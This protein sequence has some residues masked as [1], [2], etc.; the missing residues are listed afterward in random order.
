[1]DNQTS[2]AQPLLRMDSVSKNY[3]VARGFFGNPLK[4]VSAVAN[5]SVD[6]NHGETLAIVGESGSGKSTMGRMIVRLID[7]SSG[8]ISFEGKAT[9]T[10]DAEILAFRK[11]VQIVFQDPRSSLNPRRKLYDILLDPLLLHGQATRDNGKQAVSNLLERVGLAPGLRYLDR[12][13]GQFSGGQLQRVAIARAIS[14]R[15]KLI[16][17]DEP[18][19]A[20]DASVR[21]QILQLIRDEQIKTGISFVFITHDLAVARNIA[22]RVAVMYLGKMVEVGPVEKVLAQ[23]AHPYTRA[24]L[25][26]TP[27]PDPRRERARVRVLLSG[28]IPSPANPPP[29]CRFHTRCPSVM[30]ICKVEEPQSLTLSPGHVAACHLHTQAA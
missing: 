24:L 5:V 22:H 7:P 12:K 17:A 3:V 9:H 6:I 19:S 15:P 2:K 16:V 13:P 4:T 29:G 18:V 10:G 21:A 20:L 26:A 27:S 11:D 14:L 23:P 30:P 28:E 8:A 1:M 25:S